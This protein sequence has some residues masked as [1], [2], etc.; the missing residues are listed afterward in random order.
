[1]AALPRVHF[2]LMNTVNASTGLS[3]FQLWLGH[4][5]QLIPPIVAMQTDPVEVQASMDLHSLLVLEAQ[6]NLILAKV[7]QAFHANK[8]CGED[9]VYSVGDKV[10]LSTRNRSKELKAGDPSWAAKFLP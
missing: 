4:S 2:V 7:N 3:P 10:L 9:S 6:D 1:M 5:P 8:T